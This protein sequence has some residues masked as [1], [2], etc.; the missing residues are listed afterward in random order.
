MNSK[1]LLCITKLVSLNHIEMSVEFENVVEPRDPRDPRYQWELTQQTQLTQPTQLI[2][3]TQLT[4]RTPRTSQSKK[5]NTKICTTA[6]RAS[7]RITHVDESSTVSSISAKYKILLLGDSGVGKTNLMVRY[8][9]GEFMPDGKPTIG[10]DFK[11]TTISAN[12]DFVGLQ[13]WDTAGLEQHLSLTSQ[14]YRDADGVVVVFDL[15]RRNTFD[16][17][18]YWM[19]EIR[20][21]C[22]LNT[23][24]IIAI[25]NKSDL[26][27]NIVITDRDIEDLKKLYRVEYFETSA[28]DHSGIDDA[29]MD[30]IQKVWTHRFYNPPVKP[31]NKAPEKLAD[32]K[33]TK[34]TKKDDDNGG[35]CVIL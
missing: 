25:G 19:N 8:L 20:K 10:V 16:N 2:Q 30:L 6:K 26:Q 14:Y 27:S 9:A 32:V 4:Q 31:T 34:S 23:V 33:P 21:N 11:S 18:R 24:K 17:V 28:K 1:C 3:P 13:I 12:G 29:F 7:S 22:D 15:T 35:C 5:H